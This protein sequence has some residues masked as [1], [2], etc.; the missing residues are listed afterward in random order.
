MQMRRKRHLRRQSKTVVYDVILED[1]DLSDTEKTTLRLLN[2]D[3][4][5]VSVWQKNGEDWK[6]LDTKNRGKYVVCKIDGTEGTLCISYEGAAK[7][8]MLFV[9]M[10][11]IAA[12][13]V[14]FGAVKLKKGRK[15]K[16]QTGTEE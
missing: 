15:Q 7:K 9:C 3:K 2:E 6:E 8:T 10:A 16:K 12:V 11:G 5:K 13:A 14:I 4:E 1:R